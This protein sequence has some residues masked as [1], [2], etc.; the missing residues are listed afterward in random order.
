MLGGT[1]ILAVIKVLGDSSLDYGMLLN[2]DKALQVII[3]I[4]VSVALSFVFGVIVMWLSRLVFTFNYKKHSRYSIAIFGGIAFT[5]LAYFI[6]MKG[7]G[8]SPYLPENIR[9]YID[10]NISILLL[11]TFIGSTILMEVM[12]LM[13][14]NIF[15]FVCLMVPC[16]A[17]ASRAN[18]L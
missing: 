15:K 16:P 7:M 1:F 8:K 10:G 12:H 2:S 13:K 14:I 4:F 3:A 5:S 18:D 17:M 9:E 6:F 11:Y